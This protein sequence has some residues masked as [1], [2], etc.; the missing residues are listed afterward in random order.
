MA[1]TEVFPNPTVKE[2]HFEIRFPNLFYIESKIGEFQLQIMDRFPKSEEV[3]QRQVLIADLGPEGKLNLPPEELHGPAVSKIWKFTSETGLEVDARTD[4]LGI[5]STRHRTYNN[6]GASERFRD[7]I[8]LVVEKFLMVTCLPMVTRVGLRYIN[9]CP[10]P[11]ALTNSEFQR[12]YDTALALHRFDLSC[13][14]EMGFRTI[15]SKGTHCLTYRETLAKRGETFRLTLDLDAFS[16]EV[17]PGSC[18]AVTDELHNTI[19]AEFEHSIK[20]PVYDYMRAG[21]PTSVGTTHK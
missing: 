9:D 16:T 12:F 5:K 11:P 4:H 15:V 2:V 19:V 21:G 13:A 14:R 3:F 18:L 6:P 7:L 10:V 8:E 1:I 17:T 20:G